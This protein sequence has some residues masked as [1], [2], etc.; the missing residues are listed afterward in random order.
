[1]SPNVKIALIALGVCAAFAWGDAVATSN[2][3]DWRSK[4]VPSLPMNG[5]D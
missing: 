3:F 2:G 1:M 5:E 4:L